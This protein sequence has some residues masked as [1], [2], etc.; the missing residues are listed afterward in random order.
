MGVPLVDLCGYLFVMHACP[1]L[2]TLLLLCPVG[3]GCSSLNIKKP[4]ASV[5]GMSV[6]DVNSEGFS[7]NFDVHVRNPNSAALP[8]SQADYTLGVGGAEL[9]DG[10]AN[11]SGSIPANGSLAVTLP[12]HVT[13]ERLLT[14]EEAIRVSGGNVPYDLRAGLS[15]D[16]GTPVVGKVRVPLRHSGTL[17]LRRVLSDP[18]ALLRSPAAKRLAAALLVRYLG[19]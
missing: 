6:D 1:H 3:A 11:P 5:T 16:S 14:A 4:T 13:F 10:K 9:L 18:E 8:L 15:F 7:L 19:R 2:I 17:P 12:V